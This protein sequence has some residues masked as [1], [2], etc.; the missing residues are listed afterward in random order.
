MHLWLWDWCKYFVNKIWHRSWIWMMQVWTP[1]RKIINMSVLYTVCCVWW[2]RVCVCVCVSECVCM[3]VCVCVCEWVC[4]YVSVWVSVC[5]WVCV[6]GWGL[7]ATT[8]LQVSVPYLLINSHYSWETETNTAPTGSADWW[9]NH[10]KNVWQST[11]PAGHRP[12]PWQNSLQFS[13][14]KVRHKETLGT[15][16][17]GHVQPIVSFLLLFSNKSHKNLSNI[18]K[19]L[20]WFW[21]S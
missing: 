15:P 17:S 2:A 19:T 14:A 13:L 21:F 10:I 6:E 12:L 18:I 20:V 5:V 9:S 8:E 1:L 11:V 7:T 3:W 16:S 4:V